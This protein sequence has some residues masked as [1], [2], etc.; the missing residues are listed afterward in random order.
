[1]NED[2]D[3]LLEPLA[4][5]PVSTEQDPLSKSATLRTRIIAMVVFLT[6]PL[7]VQ[8]V[9]ALR[10]NDTVRQTAEVVGTQA[11]PATQ[12]LLN[13][14]RDSYQAQLALERFNTFGSEAGQEE[15]LATLN[16]NVGQTGERFA[17]VQEISLSLPGE[18]ELSSEYLELRQI[19]IDETDLAI[20]AMTAAKDAA[21]AFEQALLFGEPGSEIQGAAS[22]ARVEADAQLEIQ[23]AA[24]EEMRER[25]DVLEE[26]IYEAETAS[27]LEDMQSGAATTGSLVLLTMIGGALAG[28][29]AA[30]FIGRSISKLVKDSTI[31]LEEASITVDE[32][33][34]GLDSVAE[35]TA[36][37]VT[38]VSRMVGDVSSNITEAM[39]AVSNF[40][41]SI[42]EISHKAGRASAVAQDAATKAQS[43][44]Q[45]VAKLGDSSQ[46]IG[47]VIEVI[48]SIAKQTNL[49]ALNATIEAAR[50]GE[51]GKG[52]GVVANEVKDLAKQTAAATEQI[53]DQVAAIQE[54]T[55]ESVQAIESITAV[56]DEIAGIQTAI[57]SAVEQQ[58]ATTN[59]I[60]DRVQRAV[61]TAQT[62]NGTVQQVASTT[63]GTIEDVK[64]S[65]AAAQDVRRVAEELRHL[66]GI[67]NELT[68]V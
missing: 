28:A 36:S 63:T 12:L 43:T 33:V 38:E 10:A 9:I 29:V 19:W 41:E 13:V 2:T 24:F 68:T 8:G 31:S 7:L 45:S 25:V 54:D 65:R 18:A 55:E 1:M 4:V 53:S 42:D 14:D 16:E 50:A 22:E 34:D 51:A 39:Q 20:A 48:T 52:F 67:S 64:T 15:L 32:A 27:L 35:T 66:A 37:S 23:R 11:S 58:A 40:S 47:Q 59:E 21:D 49:L 46:E 6:I 5:G 61:D 3:A 26:Q 30:M 56:I 62:I 60:S 17:K 57:A 44:N